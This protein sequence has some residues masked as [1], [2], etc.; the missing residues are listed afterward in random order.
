MLFNDAC[1]Q[2]T[3]PVYPALN[4][5]EDLGF[6]QC[7]PDT[8]PLESKKDL[9]MSAELHNSLVRVFEYPAGV[10]NVC[11]C[12]CEEVVGREVSNGVR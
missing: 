6:I 2:S 1:I 5:G 7:C 11:V 12:A 3:R 9:G 4:R 10:I 8:E